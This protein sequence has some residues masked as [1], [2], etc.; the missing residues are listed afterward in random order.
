M[1]ARQTWP[2]GKQNLCFSRIDFEDYLQLRCGLNGA[3]N[4]FFILNR[5]AI[6][7]QKNLR[8]ALLEMP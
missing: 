6:R 5:S 7:V 1:S 2:T 8:T 3:L 4:L